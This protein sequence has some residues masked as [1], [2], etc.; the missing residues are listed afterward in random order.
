MNS[1]GTWRTAI[2]HPFDDRIVVRGR[3]LDELVGKVSFAAMTYLEIL[4]RLPSKGEERVLDAVFV[5]CV[6][7]GIS[8]S[9]TVS[10]FLYASG[11]PLQVA[12]A[13][14]IMTFGDIHGGAGEACARML[15]EAVGSIGGDESLVQQKARS[16]V[17]ESRAAHSPLPGFGHPQHSQGDPRT[18]VLL[19]VAREEGIAGSHVRMATSIEHELENSLGRRLPLNIDGVLGALV[20]D[21]GFPWQLARLFI[22][23]PRAVGLAAHSIEEMTREGGWRHIPIAQVSYDGPLDDAV[24][25]L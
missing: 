19:G 14:G 7:H 16:I 13:G 9:T 24:P 18:P 20:S 5:A 12:I 23:T 15:Q 17:S 3:N 22:V 1:D 10:R 4:G 21:L 25:S 11:V 6:E 8:P 2:G